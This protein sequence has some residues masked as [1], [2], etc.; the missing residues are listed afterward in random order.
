MMVGDTVYQAFF[1]TINSSLPAA[2]STAINKGWT[3]TIGFFDGSMFAIAILIGIV[4]L[5]LTVWL[6]SNPV[7]LI[8]WFLVNLITFFVYDALAQMVIVIFLTPL[9]TGNFDGAYNFITSGM[10]KLLIILNMAAAL[11]LFGHYEKQ[12]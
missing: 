12:G 7:Y 3:N 1:P 8:M 11:I 5:I 2:S 10:P 9:N 6:R 4:S